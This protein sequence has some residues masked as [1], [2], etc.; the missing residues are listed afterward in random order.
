MTEGK[1]LTKA[2][3]RQFTGTEHYYRHQLNRRVVYTDGVKYMAEKGGA[4]WLI[5]EIA[6]AQAYTPEV[7]AQPFQHWTLKV[8]DN[9]GVLSCGDGN[10]RTV[11]A[12]NIEFTDFPL[13][14]I[15]FY[16]TD[17]VIMLTH[18]Y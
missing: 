15:A 6:L 1:P 5:D 3:L 11:F 9:T 8:K 18:E 14:E 7:K 17:S 12:K 13:D 2:D 10:G 4:Y 16:Y